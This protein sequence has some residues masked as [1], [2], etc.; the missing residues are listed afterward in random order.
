MP[1]DMDRT[2]LTDVAGATTNLPDQGQLQNSPL[3]AISRSDRD[4][5]NPPKPFG[6]SRKP[7]NIG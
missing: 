6:H 1:L 5:I 2:K 7:H 3:A 4:I